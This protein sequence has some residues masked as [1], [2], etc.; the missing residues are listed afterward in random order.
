LEGI[1]L[2][3]PGLGYTLNLLDK[4]TQSEF[5]AFLEDSKKAPP[6]REMASHGGKLAELYSSLSFTGA[7]NPETITYSTFDK[8]KAHPQIAAGLAAIKL[9]IL[10]TAWTV[11]CADKDIAAFVYQTLR[12]L[13]R[14][15]IRSTLTAIDYGFSAH[16]KV[17]EI[18][19]L[20]L[21]RPDSAGRNRSFFNRS[22]ATYKKIKSLH[23][24][25][26]SIRT[27]KLDNFLG[28]TQEFQ[29]ISIQINPDKAFIFTHSKGDNFGNLYGTSR[30]KNVYDV[31]Y[32]WQL[33]AQFMMRY[34]ERKGSPPI[35]GRFPPGKSKDGAT[36]SSVA[37]KVG[38]SMITDGVVTL[39]SSMYPDGKTYKWD[40]EYLMDDKRGEM[41]VSALNALEIK[42]LRGLFV[43]ERVLTQDLRTGSYALSRTHF[44]VFV[45]ELDGLLSDIE[46]H[47]TRY[48]VRPLVEY[49]F[50][51]DAP[52]TFVEMEKL[53]RDRR[54]FLAKIFFEMAKTGAIAPA[55]KEIARE[56]KIPIDESTPPKPKEEV[57]PKPEKEEQEKLSLEDKKKRW[58]RDPLPHENP[59]VLEDIEDTLDKRRNEFADLLNTEI[60]QPQLAQ[61]L[62]QV[63]TAL[64]GKQ[65]LKEIWFRK[66]RTIDAYGR[67]KAESLPWQPLKSKVQSTLN[68]YHK[69]FY[70]FG[71]KTSIEE[72]DLPI[73]PKTDALD[74]DMLKSRAIAVSD[75]WLSNIKYAWLSN[76]KYATEMA[77]LKA[78]NKTPED[79]KWDVKQEFE[80]FKNKNLPDIAETEGMTALNLG[81]RRVVL[82][83]S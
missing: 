18:K 50:G 59:K 43:P 38:K 41:F 5:T 55:V 81:R 49:N 29:A 45:M 73:K 56:L 15:L 39:P 67:E 82:R 30:L 77:I 3:L 52:A 22:A 12:P 60:L 48:I 7:Y 2:K 19:P 11:E 74:L 83:H 62:K 66:V 80:K 6:T 34:F 69:E 71:Q 27:D 72:M 21:K 14:G 10:A 31:W 4:D 26:I 25:Y 68:K 61:V 24:E 51:A 20:N 32:W 65:P 58:W 9:P 37:L 1:L 16:E 70:L 13:W 57:Q 17:W 46:D 35:V 47:F 75:R 79:M 76:I 64:K 63:D 33:L 54:E 28:I 40:V 8:M 23:P 42:M 44:N 36:H 78:Q 53:S